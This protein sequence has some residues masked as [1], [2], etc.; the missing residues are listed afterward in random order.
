MLRNYFFLVLLIFTGCAS[1]PT[2]SGSMETTTTETPQVQAPG[3]RQ[4]LIVTTK[5]WDAVPGTLRRF[6][7][8][9]GQWQEVTPAIEVVVGKKGMGWGKGVKDFT[10]YEGPVKR[11]GD[12]KSPA[13]IFTLGTAFGYASKSAVNWIKT[14]YHPVTALTMCI[15]DGKSAHYNQILDEGTARADWNSTDHMLRKDDLYEWGMFV[16]HNS[17]SPAAGGG[18]C[19]FLHVA[20]INDDGTAGC[21]AMAK[22]LMLE[23]LHWID[24]AESPLLVQV[25]EDQYAKFQKMYQLPDIGR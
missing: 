17:P 12:L 24:A 25:P 21:T 19:I 20:Q 6:A 3:H 1:Q 18:S 5:D 13:G 22:P 14:E 11:E 8:K 16:E 9:E 23:I 10:K 4:L 7:W 2:A 15:E